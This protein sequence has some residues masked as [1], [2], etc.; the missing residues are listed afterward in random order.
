VQL[1]DANGTF[2]NPI[3]IGST[4][5]A[6]IAVCTIPINIAAGSNYRIRVVSTHQTLT[7]NNNGSNLSS[8][9]ASI[10]LVSPTNDVSIG[11]TINQASQSITATNKLLS[12]SNTIYKAGNSILLNAGFQANSSSVFKAE[13]VGCN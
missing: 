8:V 13:I 5:S 3:I 10:N 11:A 6:G 4:P 12:S 9:T 7:G 1:S 2:D